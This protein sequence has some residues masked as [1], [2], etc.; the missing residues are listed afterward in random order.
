[1]RSGGDHAI[2]ARELIQQ[3]R[4]TRATKVDHIWKKNLSWSGWCAALTSSISF[5]IPQRSSY[6]VG[7]IETS[8]VL[9]GIVCEAKVRLQRITSKYS[10]AGQADAEKFMTRDA[11]AAEKF[12][13]RVS[14]AFH[15]ADFFV[16][17]TVA[18]FIDREPNEDW[19]INEKGS[20]L[21]ASPARPWSAPIWQR[22]R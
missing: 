17:N 15:M 18:R 5:G 19:D 12:G 20:D 9:V 7:C 14:D 13:Q 1:M 8:F 2:V 10:N 22:L 6:F 21:S 11:R 16:D 3:I 4:L